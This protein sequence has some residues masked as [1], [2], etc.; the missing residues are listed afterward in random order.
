MDTGP[1]LVDRR[2]TLLRPGII[3]AAAAVVVLAGMH[4]AA[5]LVSLL[6]LS[7]LVTVLLAPLQRRL[8]D[9]GVHGI[10]TLVIALAVYLAV[11]GIAG[12]LL[13]VGLAGFL[14]D[15][16]AYQDELGAF[17]D[18]LG[19][20]IGGAGTPA[21]IDVE[22]IGATIRSLAGDIV[23]ALATVGYSVI[24]VAYLLLE[25]PHGADRLRW[26][27]GA[28]TEAVARGAALAGRLRAYIV[29]RAILGA[30]A[31]VLD[32]TLLLILGVP[33]AL[34]WGILSFLLSFIPNVGFILA[35]IPPT[36]LGL[37]TGGPL[38]ALAVLVGYSV[39]NVA[40]DY[41][42]QPRF[43]GG[44]V[45]LSAVTVTVCLLFWAVVLGG[46][47]A[48]L[49]VPLTIMVAAACDAFDDTRPLARLLGDRIGPSQDTATRPG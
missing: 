2:P 48:L 25:A 16:P 47:G 33:A 29:A 19:A 43:I 30:V 9:R 35:L 26:A 18:R 15:L 21:P 31:A 39:I 40:I 24:I 32:V 17:A 12:L 1:S 13:V 28:E 27:F 11:L 3:G 41:A 4:A 6:I 44:T 37:L 49:A 10:V 5:S 22:A 14:R 38:V 20:T 42:I 45:D 36:I 8:L 23:G 46:S 7:V 34:L